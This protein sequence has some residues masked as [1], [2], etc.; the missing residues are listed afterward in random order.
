MWRNYV[1]V[2][3]LSV[4]GDFFLGSY[5]KAWEIQAIDI[6]PIYTVCLANVNNSWENSTQILAS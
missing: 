6:G 3:I 2:Y 1:Y 4:F 5:W